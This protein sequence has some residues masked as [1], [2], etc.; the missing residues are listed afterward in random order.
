MTAPDVPVNVLLDS[1][2]VS[3]NRVTLLLETFAVVPMGGFVDT[4]DA[5]R[6]GNGK[7]LTV[8]PEQ[9]IVDHWL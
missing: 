3:G 4:R 9:E 5:V 6:D 8:C 1:E 7:E 2:L